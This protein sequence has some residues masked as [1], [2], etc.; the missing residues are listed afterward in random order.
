MFLFPCLYLDFVQLECGR[1]CP[2][3]VFYCGS[4]E[5]IES[6]VVVPWE[7]CTGKE[8]KYRGPRVTAQ[9]GEIVVFALNYPVG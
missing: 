4:G 1:L 9:P 7:V 5:I 6:G 8:Q 2:S 3:Q